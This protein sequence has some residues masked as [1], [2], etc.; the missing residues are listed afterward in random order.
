MTAV[1]FSLTIPSDIRF[2]AGRLAE[3]PEVIT[4]WGVDSAL[5]I[6]GRSSDRVVDL[7]EALKVADVDELRA[8]EH[9]GAVALV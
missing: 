8:E 7:L 9:D 2:G 3:V 6:T 4:S 5:V 1:D